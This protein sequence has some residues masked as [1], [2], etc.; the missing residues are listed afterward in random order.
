[1]SEQNKTTRREL[2]ERSAL[3]AGA[4]MLLA[5]RAE[6]PMSPRRL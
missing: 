6:P 1:M 2:L 4:G 5:L 3:A